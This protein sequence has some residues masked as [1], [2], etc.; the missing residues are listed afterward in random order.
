MKLL[1]LIESEDS[2]LY[3]QLKAFKAGEIPANEIYDSLIA[4]VKNNGIIFID[5]ED[6]DNFFEMTDMP[7]YEA[8]YL[9]YLFNG[10][11][12]YGGYEVF[13]HYTANDDWNEGYVIRTLVG[14]ANTKLLHLLRI[15]APQ[16]SESLEDDNAIKDISQLLKDSFSRECDDI[17]DEYVNIHNET[18]EKETIS[19]V[20]KEL[21]NGFESYGFI[22]LKC[23][24]KYVIVIDDLIEL[25]ETYD[26][27]N[28]N[29]KSLFTA[30]SLKEGFD[31]G[32][33]VESA[34]ENMHHFSSA[35]FSDSVVRYIDDMIEK[36]EDS[37]TFLD[38]AEFKKILAEI[39]KYGFNNF[40]KLPKDKLKEFK[41]TR[42]NPETNL[43]D[44]VVRNKKDFVNK[45]YEL[46][47][48]QFNLLLYQPELFED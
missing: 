5:F 24:R 17:I 4:R 11:G 32:G 9:K 13:D 28:C 40:M 30:L 43:I 14:E 19:E 7:D 3:N 36:I 41:I 10:Y 27:T 21:C 47:V 26:C 35:D 8:S 37:D 2:S 6:S 45:R 33:W 12:R 34:N 39:T 25:L 18:A 16:W 1:R 23:F 46:D 42:I 29:L 31:N 22:T 15:I 48:E 44:V 38:L 20:T